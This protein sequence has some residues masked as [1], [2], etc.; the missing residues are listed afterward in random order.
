MALSI[1]GCE[2]RVTDKGT[3]P[4]GTSW[5]HYSTQI[6]PWVA[7]VTH[8]ASGWYG[9]WRLN[10]RYVWGDGKSRHSSECLILEMENWLMRLS[11]DTHN[12]LKRLIR[13]E[14]DD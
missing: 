9:T 6:G 1:F 3:N 12:E 8:G 14:T 5:R 7:S 13:S 10:D 11:L 4:N 2:I